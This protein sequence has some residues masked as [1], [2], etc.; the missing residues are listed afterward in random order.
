MSDFI[1]GQSIVEEYGILPLEILPRFINNGLVPRNQHTGH[2]ISVREFLYPLFGREDIDYLNDYIDA[3]SDTDWVK[4][5]L[6]LSNDEI[7]P[8]YE[9]SLFALSHLDISK[10]IT[11][12][13]L[14]HIYDRKKYEQLVALDKVARQGKVA[15]SV[16]KGLQVQPQK[17]ART[18]ANHKEILQGRAE[19]I[20]AVYPDMHLLELRTY[21]AFRKDII[22]KN[23]KKYQESFFQDCLKGRWEKSYAGPVKPLN[24]ANHTIEVLLQDL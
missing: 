8:N 20:W 10:Y 23:G 5:R 16:E 2:P 12:A 4:F 19:R 6:P 22:K 14:N 11:E 9:S 3:N 7:S 1:S 21:P 18:S 13:L 17:T 15:H 24:I